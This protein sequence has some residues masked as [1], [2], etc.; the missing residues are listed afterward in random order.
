MGAKPVN[1]PQQPTQQKSYTYEEL[2]K[3]G[4]KPSTDQPK[5]PQQGIGTAYQQPQQQEEAPEKKNLARGIV[6][7]LGGGKMTD[8]LKQVALA[9]SPE[10]EQIQKDIAEGRRNWK[11]VEQLV[12]KEV[13][14]KDASL[15]AAEMI[16]T[17]G[18]I[19]GGTAI[20]AGQAVAYKVAGKQIA[21]KTL[22]PAAKTI[23][24]QIAGPEVIAS[25]PANILRNFN[26]ISERRDLT[27]K[28]K[29]AEFSKEMVKDTAF[30]AAT[31]V[32]G[33]A[34]GATLGKGKQLVK[35][36][37]K[38]VL[39]ATQRLGVKAKDLP[40]STI[41]SSK[42][43]PLMEGIAGKSWFGKKIIKQIDETSE[44]LG[45]LADEWTSSG[46]KVEAG[47]KILESFQS[48]K[49][50]FIR[51]KAVLYSNADSVLSGSGLKKVKIQA[52]EV[53]DFI[54]EIS[55]QEKK[56]IKILGGSSSL[57]KLESLAK[58]LKKGGITTEEAMAVIKNLQSQSKLF[59]DPLA[60]GDKGVLKKVIAQLQGSVDEVYKT[61]SPEVSQS[62]DAANK[63]YKEN[64][65]LL[66]SKIGK[67]VT[68]LAQQPELIAG[69][70]IATNTSI[71]QIKR[72]KGVV[73]EDSV[74]QAGNSIV[75]DL[76]EK[77]SKSGKFSP[78]KFSSSLDK[79]GVVKLKEMLPP[80]TFQALQDIKTISRKFGAADKI[81]SGSQTAFLN[82][83]LADMA[84]GLGYFIHPSML[85]ALVVKLVGEAGLAAFLTSN[86]GK[87]VAQQGINLGSP[88]LGSAI[89]GAKKAVT[90]TGIVKE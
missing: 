53:V 28:Q 24:T 47:Q 54:K 19:V 38:N 33:E 13:S 65:Q 73:G 78:A 61:A 40:F 34:L 42:V 6:D 52:P 26:N 29:I 21:A 43:A 75:R 32:G 37:S 23:L 85:K 82:N 30:D 7:F 59:T 68:R 80:K 35:G 60:T 57:T 2:V 50:K 90:A 44:T 67:D 48:F 83:K 10:F 66:N 79:Y 18:A 51:T 12:G 84:I 14:A 15:S 27:T 86:V 88:A 76:F 72:L 55:T 77:S 46:N 1:E 49:Q 3:G 63:Y 39:D 81:L 4:A 45:R 71:E 8:Y 5:L 11:D 31:G 64:I 58:K 41:S 16:A 9:R 69:K 62:I 74:Y 87:K 70:L 20:G 56:A 89:R 17:T 36:A 22:L 25:L